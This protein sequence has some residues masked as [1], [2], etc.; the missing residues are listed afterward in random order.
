MSWSSGTN[1]IKEG[2]E[3]KSL[4]LQMLE[5]KKQGGGTEYF[6]RKNDVKLGAKH[7]TQNG[8]YPAS[9]DGKVGFSQVTVNVRGGN[10]SADSHGKPTGG[11]IKPGGAGS[12]VVGTDPETGNDVVVGV[13]EDGNL[14]NTPL[15]SSIVL[16]T[17]PTKMDYNDGES[18]DLSGAVVVA[19]MADGT[20]WTDVDHP[21][22]HVSCS[23][24]P[25]AADAS[26]AGGHDSAT[27]DLDTSP[28]VQPII[29][30]RDVQ[31]HSRKRKDATTTVDY[32]YSVS[33]CDF[34][35]FT[36]PSKTSNSDV[37]YVAFSKTQGETGTVTYRWEVNGNKH[38]MT[39]DVFTNAYYSFGG[40]TAYY[41]IFPLSYVGQLI[42]AD[43]TND[44]SGDAN[45]YKN[46]AGEAAWTC[47]YGDIATGGTQ[48]IT[49]NWAR[50]GDGKVLST[51]MEI[52]VGA[53]S[54][55]S[56]S[57]T[58]GSGGGGSF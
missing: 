27:S 39:N 33:G 58:E 41:W 43:G 8:T 48:S 35:A 32:Y 46:K 10:G 31:I 18:I 5:V 7:I 45:Q 52:T 12:A 40:K 26:Q 50:P 54:T 30:G 49:L 22:G 17:N 51:T 11:D 16:V 37:I 47:L 24:E 42:S 3:S 19:K 53:H 20:T 34:I 28:I 6:V 4:T 57:G 2:S 14:V 15:P 29:F 9:N 23:C 25:A 44:Y 38:T 56:S 36:D 13:D 55:E 21:N 1:T